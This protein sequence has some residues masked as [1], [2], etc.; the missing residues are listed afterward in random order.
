MKKP[1]KMDINV[2]DS[3]VDAKTRLTERR[4]ST[5]TRYAPRYTKIH[6]MKKENLIDQYSPR[7][8]VRPDTARTIDNPQNI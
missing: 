8:V 4:S 1:V 5:K 3:S 7:N 6:S 2:H